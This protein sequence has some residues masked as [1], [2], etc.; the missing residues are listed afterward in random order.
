[1]TLTGREW[2]RAAGA[3]KANAAELAANADL[4]RRQFGAG[5]TAGGAG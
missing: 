5:N 1:M 2:L 4:Q 3:L